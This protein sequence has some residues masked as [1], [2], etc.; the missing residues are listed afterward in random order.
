LQ[1]ST[2]RGVL[3]NPIIEI[4]FKSSP[5]RKT[6][7]EIQHMSQTSTGRGANF[8]NQ[9]PVNLGNVCKFQGH[10]CPGLAMGLHHAHVAAEIICWHHR[11]YIIVN[12]TRQSTQNQSPLQWKQYV[13]ITGFTWAN[14][15]RQS[16]QN[17]TL[18]Q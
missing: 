4:L 2:L 11:C 17:Q 10:M 15:T 5:G 9:I 16:T 13:G 6:S 1:T 8:D 7:T 3:Q 18:L 14:N 12:V